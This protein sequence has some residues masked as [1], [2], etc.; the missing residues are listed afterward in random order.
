M[1]TLR[2]AAR[3]A[4]I[5]DS[6]LSVRSLAQRSGLTP[7]ISV[8]QLIGTLEK[9][10]AAVNFRQ[11]VITPSGTAL[12]G[13]V[14]LTLRSDGTYVAYFHMRAT[15]FPNYVFTVRALFAASNGLT[16]ALQNSGQVEGTQS[17]GLFESPRRA[18][19]KVLQGS[20]PFIKEFWPDIKA[21]RLAV[22]KEY[23]TSG[24]VGF[25]EDVA[26]T[27]LDITTTVAR[28][29]AGAVI[30]LGDEMLAAFRSLELGGDI[31]VIAGYAVFASGGG[32][33][34]AV[35]TGAQAGLVTK[36]LIKYRPLEPP[37]WNFANQV[38][39]GLEPKSSLPPP[40]KIMLTNLE[41]L[42]QRAF[43]MPGTAGNIYVNIG[44]YGYDHPLT[45]QRYEQDAPGQLFI[46]ELTHVW[47]VHNRSFVPGWVRSG[48]IVQV[49]NTFGNAYDYT[50][51]GAPPWSDFE[52]E[53]QAAIVDDWFGGTRIQKQKKMDPLDPYFGY[54]RDN[55]R[56]G[57]L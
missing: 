45:H 3:K 36:A 56:K 34:L 8:R 50:R 52:I 26:R 6:S 42:G 5:T 16:F 43:V 33:V 12:G 23:S 10:P 14:D 30:A 35:T 24:V 28:G 17:T 11:A 47:Q 4:A 32:L 20:H 27:V 29:A 44:E 53:Q 40:D 51:E 1:T 15:G 13:F 22:S 25:I 21:G 37:E 18:H 31:G 9:G 39:Q 54:I 57:R 19:D 2:E 7:P 48:L 38:F 55:V 46:H 41:G 49:D